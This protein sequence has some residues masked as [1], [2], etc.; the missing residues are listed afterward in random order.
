MEQIKNTRQT[1]HYN[2]FLNLMRKNFIFWDKVGKKKFE[3]TKG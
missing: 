1:Q 2:L 3:I